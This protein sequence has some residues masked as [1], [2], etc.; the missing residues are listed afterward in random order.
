MSPFPLYEVLYTSELDPSVK[1]STIA[2]IVRR[3]RLWNAAHEVTGLLVFDGGRFCHHLE[4]PAEVVHALALRISA[5]ARHTGFRR[6][7]AATRIGPRR[8]E[9]HPLSYGLAYD[10]AEIDAVTALSGVAATERLMQA[11]PRLELEP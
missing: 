7:H 2:D 9:G 10:E 4:G 3:A 8:L 6:L 11:L 1:V 5:D